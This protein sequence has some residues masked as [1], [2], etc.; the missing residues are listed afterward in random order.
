[1]SVKSQLP[2]VVTGGVIVM[3]IV[4]VACQGFVDA[5]QQKLSQKGRCAEE[6][7]LSLLAETSPADLT[8]NELEFLAKAA[9][10]ENQ[11]NADQAIEQLRA[12]GQAGLDAL[13]NTHRATIEQA[14]TAASQPFSFGASAWESP[15]LARL[16][17]ALE[18][19][20]RQYDAHASCLFWHTDLEAA[21]SEAQS[22]GKPILSLRLLG[23]LDEECSCAN[24]RFFRTALYANNQ[25]ADHLR[26]N[27]VLHW[28]SVRP[29]P[30][31]TIDFGDGRVMERTITGN[32]IH[33]VL[34]PD[35]RLVDGLP[36]LYGPQAFLN[37]LSQIQEFTARMLV[38]APETQDAMLK[39]YHADS[40]T[41]LAAQMRSDLAAVEAATVEAST[42]EAT[43]NVSAETIVVKAVVTNSDVGGS[44]NAA[45]AGELAFGKSFIETPILTAM[46]I[47]AEDARSNAELTESIS[48]EMW[49]RIAALHSDN[50]RLDESSVALMR[51]HQ[52]NAVVASA[53]TVSKARIEDPMV[54]I[55]T[56]FERSIAEDTVR[57]EY[58][59]RRQIHEWFAL[60]DVPPREVD[61][62]NE[63]VYAQLFLTPSS[64]PWLGL[65]SGEYSALRADGLQPATAIGSPKVN[66]Q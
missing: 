60:A 26:N 3:A 20:S 61:P 32:S 57:N 28:K 65:M 34:T 31:I 53:L 12:A 22:T 4:V 45:Q 43:E 24:S 14:R 11:A 13:F 47:T 30:K 39:R 56:N 37:N 50:S 5:Q 1:M 15:E 51:E 44:I 55:V 40:A 63:R 27:F 8:E 9:V 33:Y 2:K 59:F 19:V 21:K 52:P 54:R 42:A 10:S 64:D 46:S 25:V 38:S 18:A 62:F 17:R 7:L 6:N 35:G 16:K 49:T 29:V 36:G 66:H 23:K 41:S 58:I 48:D